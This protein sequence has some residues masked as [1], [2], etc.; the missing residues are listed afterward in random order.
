MKI[1][2]Y[3][4]NIEITSPTPKIVIGILG[5]VP[6]ILAVIISLTFLWI[7]SIV[8]LLCR[9]QPTNTCG[10]IITDPEQLA[11]INLCRDRRWPDP[12]PV[13]ARRMTVQA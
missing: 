13:G 10:A 7:F 9:N 12:P 6:W 5:F 11:L 1:D 3:F 4:D 2:K 8:E